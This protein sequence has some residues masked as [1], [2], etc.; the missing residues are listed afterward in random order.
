MGWSKLAKA[1]YMYAWGLC[2][3]RIKIYIYIGRVTLVLIIITLFRNSKLKKKK[4]LISHVG[5]GA[6]STGGRWYCQG[7]IVHHQKWN[8]ISLTQYAI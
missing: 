8:E 3:M 7:I 4:N 6:L 2:F 5:T 1:T